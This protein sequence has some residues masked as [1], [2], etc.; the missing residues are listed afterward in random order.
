M[1]QKII[2]PAQC[3]KRGALYWLFSIVHCIGLTIRTSLRPVQCIK[4]GAGG[5]NC[6][7]P[8][9]VYEPPP[10]V[11]P[12]VIQTLFNLLPF[13]IQTLFNLCLNFWKMF[14]IC[15][16]SVILSFASCQYS[17]IAYWTFL[18]CTDLCGLCLSFARW[19]K[20]K[21]VQMHPLQNRVKLAR[22]LR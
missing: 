17:A 18:H 3:I 19:Q 5:L 20:L 2:R 10:F 14:T 22:S 16:A 21:T 9:V 8:M 7:Q 13:V 11:W 4:R 6:W 15:A 12:F 1:F